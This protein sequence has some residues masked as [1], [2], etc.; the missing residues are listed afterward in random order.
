MKTRQ[1]LID[2]VTA[3][4]LLVLA[5]V[6]WL[7]GITF[8]RFA[9]SPAIVPNATVLHFS[10]WLLLLL[11]LLFF[12]YVVA[13]TATV[14]WL[15]DE[16]FELAP[17]WKLDYKLSSVTAAHVGAALALAREAKGA[18]KV[19]AEEHARKMLDQALVEALRD[20]EA[21]SA[22][23]ESLGRLGKAVEWSEKQADFRFKQMS[24]MLDRL[25][26][27][28]D[29]EYSDLAARTAWLLSGLAFMLGAF[30][31]ILNGDSLTAASRRDMAASV[32]GAGAVVSFLLMVSA[33]FAY[34]LVNA[35]KEPRGLL[36]ERM[37]KECQTVPAGVKPDSPT[38]RLAHAAT[39]LL[40]SFSYVA[41]V[42][43]ALLTLMTNVFA[44]RAK[45]VPDAG[46]HQAPVGG[47]ARL[48]PSS[49]AFPIG[50]AAYVP[51]PGCSDQ[52]EKAALWV[53][54][55]VGAWLQRKTPSTSDW[56]VLV[57]S[58]DP[59]GLN[60]PLK[61]KLDSNMTLARQR[62]DEIK[63]RLRER[64]QGLGPTHAISEQ[65]VLVLVTGSRS[66]LPS[67]NPRCDDLKLAEDRKVEVWLPV[68][69]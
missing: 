20:S 33:F 41:W 50:K 64:T 27:R 7:L 13:F 34:T 68:R 17:Q 43:L 35:L 24:Y 60:G 54:Q 66:M 15:A 53:D 9:P 18:D 29:G 8:L 63:R 58:A 61:T 48:E 46:N 11:A 5:A 30:V 57:G 14:N 40:P 45:P 28:I 65:R 12:A 56:L 21:S 52:S 62:A 1:Q 44:E 16:R 22:F 59:L 55:V 36:E 39:R 69:N 47:L 37:A 4:I 25:Q 38:H 42:A 32:A 19:A 23:A 6:P 31:A 2:L 49:P 67:G 26:S 10:W 51:T 3:A